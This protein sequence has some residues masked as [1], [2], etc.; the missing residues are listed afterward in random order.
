[1][2][3][4]TSPK[5]VASA[6]G[7]LVGATAL[8]LLLSPGCKRTAAT[9]IDRQQAVDSPLARA[10]SVVVSGPARSSFQ[11]SNWIRTPTAIAV[12]LSFLTLVKQPPNYSPNPDAPCVPAPLVFEAFRDHVK[13]MRGT[14]D[15]PPIGLG[16]TARATLPGASFEVNRVAIYTDCIPMYTPNDQTPFQITL[17]NLQDFVGHQALRTPKDSGRDRGSRRPN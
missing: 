5:I 13:I 7:V 10:P 2:S 1:M 4:G 3:T 8:L 12:D 14:V 17:Q 6:A 16:E 9:N 15:L 11:F